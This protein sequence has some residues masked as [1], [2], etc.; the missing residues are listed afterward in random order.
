MNIKSLKRINSLLV[1]LILIL[2][3]DSGNPISINNNS[4][5]ET[6][7]QTELGEFTV[8]PQST[9]LEIKSTGTKL[10]GMKLEVPE[11][12]F[13]TTTNFTFKFSEIKNHK[14]GTYF[15]PITPMIHIST[16][17]GFTDSVM[18]LTIPINLIEGQFAMA[19][20]YDEKTGKLE[21]LPIY[22][23]N[24]NSISVV[25]SH[26]NGSQSEQ[27]AL[28]KLV[29]KIQ[30]ELNTANIIVTAIDIALLESTGLVSTK[31]KPGVDDWEFVNDGSYV[32]P[33]GHCAGQSITAMW[34]FYEKKLYG[35][36][37]L[38]GHYDLLNNVNFDNAK[39]YKFASVIQE[40]MDWDSW[41][42][43]KWI[44]NIDLNQ[45]IDDLKILSFAYSFVLTKEPQYVAVRREDGK[46]T[47]GKTKYAG[48]AL[49]A[50][51]IN[52]NKGELYIADP[53]YPGE[54]KIITF[55]DNGFN[56][57]IA[58]LNAKDTS[59]PYPYISYRAKSALINWDKIGKRWKEF[60]NGTIGNV[61][62]NTFPQYQIQINKTSNTLKDGFVSCSDTLYLNA[63]CP[64]SAMG[65]D[66][67]SNVMLQVYDVNGNVLADN[68]IA[69]DHLP[70]G[71]LRLILKE[72]NNT[73][74]MAIYGWKTGVV[75][76]DGYERDLF[77]DFKW[78]NVQYKKPEPGTPVISSVSPSSGQKGDK[79]TIFG[80]DFGSW[81]KVSIGNE[82]CL[83]NSWT[84]TEIECEVPD[85]ANG[86]YQLNLKSNNKTSN[87]IE[88]IIQESILGK[89]QMMTRMD[90]KCYIWV[91]ITNDLKKENQSE[92]LIFI[93]D[94]VNWNGTSFNA[95]FNSST[96]GDIFWDSTTT[97]GSISGS[98]SSDGK[99]VVSCSGNMTRIVWLKGKKMQERKE[100]FSASSLPF[101]SQY[102]YYTYRVE[103]SSVSSHLSGVTMSHESFDEDGKVTSGS[104]ISQI[105]W[106]DSF[107]PSVQCSF[108][109]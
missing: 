27:S 92:L 28:G 88:F 21:G 16:T 17:G 15:N 77:I 24:S 22:E 64:A 32:A 105:I 89:V 43:K 81:G 53:N 61:N 9:I 90:F 49:I 1:I 106:E 78:F 47:N 71:V 52:F 37:S 13:P 8:G 85:L 38:F 69:K 96:G 99:T 58:K 25:T 20:M 30:F 104:Y 102:N 59:K 86:T 97:T 76:R 14:F 80:K 82:L 60:E 66:S 63:N 10:D 98:L 107:T 42:L 26:F 95:P 103:G 44:S 100:S 23:L 7:K 50:Y 41:L 91:E 108:S 57:Y 65:Y 79:I 33:G 72:G 5:F 11:N 75:D 51:G 73:L 48:H 56:P 67:T 84:P 109:K 70:N 83:I 18:K 68:S 40:D 94:K 54:E 29:P 101:T 31:F 45:D 74:G 4:K 46:Y 6:G 35:S 3:C 55:T 93:S 87:S 12:S 36:P 2:G 19:F 34:Y 62:P 39:G